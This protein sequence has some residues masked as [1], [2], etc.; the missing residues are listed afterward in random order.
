MPH[1]PLD[2]DTRD[3]SPRVPDDTAGRATLHTAAR[4]P[5][6]PVVLAW[7][8][9]GLALAASATGLLMPTV[10]RDN[11]LVVAAFHGNDVVTLLVAVPGLVA[12][13]LGARRHPTLARFGR[14]GM[15]LYTLYNYVFYLFGAAFNA[16]F[17]V[18]VALVVCSGFGLGSGLAEADAPAL[19]RKFRA[20]TPARS[21]AAYLIGFAILLGGMWTA[22]SLTFLFTGV[23]P[24]A[25]TQTGHPT[26]VVFATDL[27][28]LVPGLLVG[29]V[30]LYRRR[31][32]GY[33]VAPIVLI[34]ASTYGI[35]MIAMSA[36]AG[37]SADPLLPL[38]AALT[39]GCVVCTG[40]LLAGL[41]R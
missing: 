35:A 14:L 38:W 25:I 16:L 11:A 12:A 13:L 17:L 41:E 27:T 15:L 24:A 9:A 31:P 29:G 39:L 7:I 32:W 28:L 30:L 40:L 22:L 5:A 37:V 26:G 18:Y 34:K 21:V 36:F 8:V 6:L 3:R 2:L 20:R 33:V 23:V 1:A 19:A 4:A 10:Y